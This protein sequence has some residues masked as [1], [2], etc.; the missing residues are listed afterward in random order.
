MIPSSPRP[1]AG[2]GLAQSRQSLGSF[3]GL[4]VVAASHEKD[5][6]RLVHGDTMGAR[7]KGCVHNR[8]H[9]ASIGAIAAEP[10]I[11]APAE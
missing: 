3:G 11:K 5:S 8:F 9:W 1:S 4:P 2:G 7:S 10:M 6:R